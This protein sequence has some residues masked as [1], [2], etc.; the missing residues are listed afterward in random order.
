MDARLEIRTAGIA[1]L[2]PIAALFAERHRRDR[3]G[4]AFLE[5]RLEDRAAARELVEPLFSNGR[6]R[7][8]VAEAGGQVAGF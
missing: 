4:V 2:E 8:A 7:V 3:T 1:D 5:P 6:A